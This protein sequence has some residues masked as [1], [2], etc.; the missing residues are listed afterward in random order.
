MK[1]AVIIGF[2]LVFTLVDIVVTTVLYAH[3]SS[4]D[5]FAD[6]LEDFD[7]HRSTLDLWG[8]VLIR[9]VLLLGA[10]IGVFFNRSDGPRRV[11]NLGTLV[12]LIC[13]TNMTYALAKML[14]LSEEGD[15]MYDP[16]FLSLFSWTCLS[17]IGTM[18]SWNQ[19]AQASS[20][21]SD[22]EDNE[23]RERLVDSIETEDE[24]SEKSSKSKNERSHSG[25]TIGRL[26]SY[27]KKDSAL[28][29]I[30]FFF[31]L[32]SAVCEAFIPYY[33]GKAID[34]IVIHKS[35]DSFTKPIITLTVLALVS[36]VA[37][38]FRGG[39]FS[40]TFARLN[41]RLR[42]VLFRSL[43]NQEIGFFDANH[44]GDITSRLTSDTTQVSDLISQNVNLF[45]RSFV[46]G[47]GMFIFMFGMS[48]KLSLVTL[49]GFPY[50]GVVSKLYGEYYKKLTKEVQ[51]AL[52]Q[53]NKVAEETISAMR[54]VR[55][56]ANE[57]QECD[58]YYNRLQ[59]MFSLNKK[60]A[61]AY[62]CYMWSSYI[63]EL[64]LQIAILFYGGHLVVTNQMS[65]GTLISF[66]IYE[67]EL[68]E[69]LENI[70]SVYTGLMQGVGAAE[71]VFEYI[72]RKP[73][74]VLD[75]QE[76]PEAFEGKVEFK[77]VTFAYPARP[78]MHIL[79][80]VSFSLCPGQITALVGPS[81]GGKS[82]CVCL[83]ENF[84]A[85][86]QGHVLVDGRPVNTYQHKYYHSQVALVAQEP[87]LF[88][89]TVQMNIS[90]GLPDVPMETVIKAAINANAHDF[91]TGLSNGYDTGV[92]EKGT[93]LSGG[94]KQ[95]VAIARALI[96][97]PRVLILDEATS[98]LDSESEYIF[99]QALNNLMREH[100][101][102]VI[103][104]RLSTVERADNILVID[105]GSVVEQGPHAELMARGGLYCKLVQRQ[106]QGT[107]LE[108][109]DLSPSPAPVLKKGD[110]ESED[111][112][113]DTE[114]EPRY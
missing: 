44:T 37:S 30:A 39:V 50:I 85:P 106:I 87:V 107:E 71:K 32:L 20:V 68:G 24:S 45:L 59:E 79:K 66:I 5:I 22:R 81:G 90:Y 23:E 12:A 56:F 2:N 35:M 18:I 41:I 101:V 58:S 61:V 113:K 25:A 74:H 78:E 6:E 14:M 49:M 70:S 86:Q 95:R 8:M 82:S 91:I 47:M 16:W 55:S 94:Q 73:K 69:A 7:I 97:N 54:T 80:N 26:L 38:G 10:S 100:T 11:S 3:G 72:D 9:A 46:K 40:L 36:S 98:A 108:A 21:V 104:H 29:G 4:L 34:G 62:A 1:V 13:L 88:A 103:A 48:W 31:L 53:A 112:C 63:S 77:N 102:L 99:Q 60:Q 65:G 42:N 15:L 75:G 43:M 67:L 93:Q 114:Y 19:M 17:A 27:C 89:R 84:Y 28:L 96:R 83:L 105:K 109:E 64:A 52:A 76:A 111:D 33:T 57:E 51:T 110:K 92:G